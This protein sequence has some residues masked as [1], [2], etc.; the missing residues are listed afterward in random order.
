MNLRKILLWGG[1]VLLA[2][3]IAFYL[4][5]LVGI[6]A[7]QEQ[8]L[9]AG[10]TNELVTTPASRG[11]DY[12]DLWLDVV[13]E[14]THGW[15]L[16]MAQARGVVLLAHG[17][18]RNISGYL[19]DAALYHDLGFSVLLYDYGGYGK[20]TGSPSEARCVADA[21]AM[22]DYLVETRGIPPGQI[23]LA[24]SSLGGGVTGALAAQV[25]P[26]AV[27]LES[28][29]TSMPDAA[30]DMLPFIPA[31]WLCRIQFR[32]MDIVER[33]SCPLLIVHSKDDAVVPFSHGQQLFAR[34]REPKLF[35]EIEGAHYGGKFQSR[36]VYTAGLRR[37]FDAY[38]KLQ[39]PEEP[40]A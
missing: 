16:P 35:V 22:W 8:L 23:V 21:R 6:W 36:E 25:A 40:G 11:W 15:W 39:Q 2:F 7:L 26:A 33:L 31:H 32:T 14:Q 3:C 1:V 38:V 4:L 30:R 28:T 13:G 12:E 37:F 18:G 29:F 24:G 34:A 27:I 10:R 20:S 9:F 5:L 19:E 17:S